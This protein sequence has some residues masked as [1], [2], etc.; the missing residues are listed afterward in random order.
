MLEFRAVRS[1][2]GEVVI[3]AVTIGIGVDVLVARVGA[4]R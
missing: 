2:D 4:R 1:E 3:G